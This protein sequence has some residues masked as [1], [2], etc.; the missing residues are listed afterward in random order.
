M[1]FLVKIHVTC[2]AIFLKAYF[3]KLKKKNGRI[4][5]ADDIMQGYELNG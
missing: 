3:L 1:I 4:A 5:I 2:I